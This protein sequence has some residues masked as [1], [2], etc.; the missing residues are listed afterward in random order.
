MDWQ[1]STKRSL[2][3]NAVTVSVASH[4]EMFPVAQRAQA[5]SLTVYKAHPVSSAVWVASSTFSYFRHNHDNSRLASPENERLGT[6]H[7]GAWQIYMQASVTRC[8]GCLNCAASGR[9]SYEIQVLRPANV[10][11]SQC[12][13]DLCASNFVLCAGRSARIMCALQSKHG[14]AKIIPQSF[15]CSIGA[16]LPKSQVLCM[17]SNALRCFV[18]IAAML[19]ENWHQDLP[20]HEHRS[21]ISSAT[22]TVD[23][24]VIA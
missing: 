20:T 10:E 23:A 24:S 17:L 19:Q 11:P 5:S 13:H 3:V 9:S 8:G 21:S 16:V 6:G 15:G 7:T 22:T 14:H 4:D 18:S 12:D 1:C 2:A